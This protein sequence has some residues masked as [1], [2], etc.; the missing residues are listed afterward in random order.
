MDKNFLED[1]LKK[2][3]SKGADHADVIFSQ[4]ENKSSSCRLGKIENSETSEVKEIGIRV[5]LKKK[6]SIISSTNLELKNLNELINKVLEMVKVVPDD[7]YCGLADK[8]QVSIPNPTEVKKLNLF[9]EYEPD[10]KKISEKVLAL[11]DSALKNKK[12]INSEG[13][14]LSFSKNKSILMGTNGLVSEINK[15][16]SDY[17]IA[18][19]AGDSNSMERAYDY[20]SKVFFNDL[21]NFSKIG[22]NVADD[23]IKKLN[24]KKI[25]TCKSNVIFDSKI[26]S[27]ILSNLFNACNASSVI[28]GI[29]F[30]KN[31]KNK[32]IFDSSINIIDDPR[33]EKKL[34]SKIVDAEGI[35]T[36]SKKLIENG[37]LKFFF[38]CLSSARQINDN[39]SGH[40]TRSASSIPSTSYTNLY[41]ENGT[42]KK[43][44][45]IK[46]I[47]KG[48]Y[49]TEL[50][51]SSVNYSNG[52]YSRGASGFWI[53]NGEI[54]YPVSE[55]TVAGN[56][57]DMFSTLV[58]A[59]DLEFNHG[60]NAPSILLFNL[61]LGGI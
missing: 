51:G 4:A 36:S 56:L 17:I 15:T 6:Q 5:I 9:D 40:A 53:E 11:E 38:N 50:M 26:S 29:S 3:K 46:S 22:K 42:K 19:L 18:V 16:H 20:K 35:K 52:D 34:R 24:S 58:P 23:A 14:E 43:E 33:M 30:L 39:P 41:L 48:L 54:S 21:G 1:I 32:R 60:I 44:D 55:V 2:L 49:V 25:K 47:K 31:K 7:E 37:K 57:Q 8:S 28:K 10:L 45:L 27:S 59:D 61:T 12:I 13:A